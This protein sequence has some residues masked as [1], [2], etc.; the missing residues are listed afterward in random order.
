MGAFIHTMG[1]TSRMH[2]QYPEHVGS[3]QVE[4]TT[5]TM[6]NERKYK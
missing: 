3:S 6:E 5:E 2:T 1:A 4:R